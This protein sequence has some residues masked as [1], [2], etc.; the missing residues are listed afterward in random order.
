MRDVYQNGGLA[1][2][3]PIQDV[4]LE[5]WEVVGH[6]LAPPHAEGVVAVREEDGL[7]LGLVVQQVALVDV[8]QLD[9]VLL[10][11]TA[12]YDFEKRGGL[13]YEMCSPGSTLGSAPVNEVVVN[14][15][16]VVDEGKGACSRAS[17]GGNEVLQSCL[18][19]QIFLEVLVLHFQ[20]TW[21]RGVYLV[22]VCMCLC[23]WCVLYNIFA[24]RDHLTFP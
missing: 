10:P 15:C 23:E 17:G 20:L 9:L 2:D 12:Q 24:N 1:V 8:G 7:Q 22:F 21:M 3:E 18:W 5:S 13:W 4:F 19:A 6:L 11:I 14:V 16:E